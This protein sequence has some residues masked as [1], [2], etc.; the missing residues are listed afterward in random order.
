MDRVACALRERPA[1]ASS[2]TTGTLMLAKIKVD[3]RTAKRKARP[4]FMAGYCINGN[5]G[6]ELRRTDH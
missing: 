1:A 6:A 3:V 4:S 2:A 5:C